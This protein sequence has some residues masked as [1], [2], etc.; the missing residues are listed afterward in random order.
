[1]NMKKTKNLTSSFKWWHALIILLIANLVSA[2]P[3]GYNGEEAFYNNFELPGI[4]PPDWLFAPVWLFNNITSL[5]ALYIVANMP[6]EVPRRKLFLWLE[7]VMWLLFAIFSI[8]YF[9]LRSPILG[10][11]DTALG[12]AATTFS[13][14]LAYDLDRRAFWYILPRFLWLLLATYVSVYVAIF[15]RDVLL[16]VGPFVH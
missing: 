10:A 7:G 13:L 3:A 4:A 8:L 12:L 11:V 2:A 9:G 5:I 15:N 1:M 14:R 16:N 6:K